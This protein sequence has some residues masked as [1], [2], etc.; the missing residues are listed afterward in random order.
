MWEWKWKLRSNRGAIEDFK[1]KKM[2]KIFNKYMVK[3][4]EN[5]N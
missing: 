1:R 3:I 5:V 4:Y 2:G